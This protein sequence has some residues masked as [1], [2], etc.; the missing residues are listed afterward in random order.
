MSDK[1][2]LT[3]NPE[4]FT[5]SNNNKT[6]KS[7][8][9]ESKQEKI[10]VK[11]PVRKKQDTLRRQSLL[12]M[13][14]KQQEDRYKRLVSNNDKHQNIQSH[15]PTSNSNA[16][17][18]FNTEFDDARE[19]LDK[20]TKKTEMN[21]P[22]NTTLRK[23]PEPNLPQSVGGT[24]TINIQ[25]SI[26]NNK[27]NDVPQYGCLKNG[28]L[29]TY[30]NFMNK[31]Q[32]NRPD[33]QIGGNAPL[34]SNIPNINISPVNPISSIPSTSIENKSSMPN[35]V[36]DTKLN[37]SMKRMSELKQQQSI[38]NKIKNGGKPKKQRRKKTVRR[39]YK[40]G[41]SSVAPKVSVLVSNKT[42]RNR[43]TT[44]SQLLKQTPI[45]EVKKYLIKHGIIR[46]GST[47]PNDVLRKMYESLSLVCG[48]IQNHNPD[49][50]LF[51]YI[52]GTD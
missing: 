30:R 47:T 9:K 27:Y 39:T 24:D 10:R 5:F 31:T 13:I 38:L 37:E 43:V 7:K 19:Y 20:L 34:G 23:Y 11:N 45:H 52:N 28:N 1:K 33:I 46:V 40:I 22:K 12:K 35:N 2:V 36:I 16:I 50:L 44:K 6:K 48:E 21:V 25:E 3:I 41:R 14:R 4:L 18:K 29:P 8:P 32:N 26:S 15:K 42:L 51:N 17:D 49:T